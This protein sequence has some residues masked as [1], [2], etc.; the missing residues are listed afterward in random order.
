MAFHA[1]IHEL[2]MGS[3]K[4]QGNTYFKCVTV[5]QRAS[6]KGSA[7][8]Y[9]KM[10]QKPRRPISM[11]N[12]NWKFPTYSYYCACCSS[13]QHTGTLPAINDAPP[14]IAEAPSSIRDTRGLGGRGWEGAYVFFSLS[15]LETVRTDPSSHA[16]LHWWN[17]LDT[18]QNLPRSVYHVARDLARAKN[19]PT[20]HSDFSGDIEA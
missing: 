4:A 18:Q 9:D 11:R 13:I 3:S 8:D 15:L 19:K 5:M 2:V 14:H 7:L 16:R 20:R 6:R 17:L 10:T 1:F 12:V